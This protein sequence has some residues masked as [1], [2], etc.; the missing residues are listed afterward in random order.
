MTTRFVSYCSFTKLPCAWGNAKDIILCL[1]D[2]A[3]VLQP[4]PPCALP[5]TT[6]EAHICQV[7]TMSDSCQR[8]L[9]Q[10]TFQ[11]ESEL[12]ANPDT[13][14]A[15]SDIVGVFC[16]DCE[17][18][19]IQ[20]QISCALSGG[21]IPF[22]VTD[23]NSVNLTVNATP[24]QDLSA[25]VKISANANNII[26]IKSDGLFADI[27]FSVTTA[28]LNTLISGSGLEPG[29][30]YEINDFVQGRIVAGAKV[31]VQATSTNQITSS[32]S[33][34]TTYD[35]KLWRG[36]Y[37]ISTNL[38]TELSDNQGNTCKQLNSSFVTCIEDFDWGNPVYTECLVDNGFWLVDYGITSV[39]ISNI[40]ILGSTIFGTTQF[41][42]RG[43][44]P[45]N[46]SFVTI[47][48]GYQVTM[49]N[50]SAVS[51][52]LFTCAAVFNDF[53]MF[54]SDAFP[55]YSLVGASIIKGGSILMGPNGTVE[56][57][58]CEITNGGTIDTSNMTGGEIIFN[59]TTIDNAAYIFIENVVNAEIASCFITGDKGGSNTI[60][61]S[62]LTTQNVNLSLFRC[63]I[64]SSL[65]SVLN[66]TQIIHIFDSIFTAGSTTNV[67]GGSIMTDV[68]NN[69]GTIT[70]NGFN[71]TNV[72]VNGNVTAACTANNTDTARDY[73]NNSII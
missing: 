62:N 44:I 15:T 17:T 47:E 61:L 1:Q 45:T 67:T 28:Q 19:W 30:M 53:S 40:R 5:I 26:S 69:I 18:E 6:I 70:T 54:D 68:S 63:F 56:V 64:Q 46:L 13:P 55:F 20:E 49:I 43:W 57:S 27:F 42:M 59:F 65:L 32:C 12:L 48:N 39:S 60:H 72:Y 33:V 58:D 71:M 3:L 36:V 29:A 31:Y 9:W 10:Y 50:A 66:S 14:L 38:L 37:D 35:T 41:D 52:T 2:A 24:S 4:D 25:D 7:F 21:E 34:L 51:S 23:T 16:Q 8:Q 73:F 22:T 11:Y